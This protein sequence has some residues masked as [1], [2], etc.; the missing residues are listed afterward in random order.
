[1]T[2]GT[3]AA[4]EAVRAGDAE[5]LNAILRRDPSLAM[6]RGDAGETLLHVASELDR[7]EVAEVLLQHGAELDAPAGWGQAPIEWAANLG[8][9]RVA[10]LLLRHGAAHDG[11]WTSSAL[12]RLDAVRACFEDGQPKEGVGRRP[13]SDADLSG[14]PE[15]SAFRRGD[16]VSDAFYIACRRGHLDVAR[17]LS[18]RGA[19]LEATG[20]FGG[21]ALHW[22]AVEGHEEVVH[23]LVAEGADTTRRDP[24]FDA[25][26]AGWAREGGHHG[27]A[28]FLGGDGATLPDPGVG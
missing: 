19:D 21:S 11:L 28:S 13:R 1:M 6:A 27:L 25:T 4:F 2:A 26:P 10:D 18:E 20:Y 9:T 22:A 24:R 16:V 3:E 8:S 12:G 14:W 17:F 7:V 15:D 23:W 5:G